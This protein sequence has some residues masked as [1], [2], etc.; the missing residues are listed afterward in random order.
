[1]SQ[2]FVCAAAAAAAV[3]AA[4]D[5]ALWGS[6]D[7]PPLPR[8]QG[9]LDGRRCASKSPGAAAALTPVEWD[10]IADGIAVSLVVLRA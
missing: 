4:V 8:R 6:F 1:M 10:V 7:I 3:D 9:P 5:A 2:R